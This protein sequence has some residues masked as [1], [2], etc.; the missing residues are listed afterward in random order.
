MAQAIV[1]EL[2]KVQQAIM[3]A[4]VRTA[5]HALDPSDIQDIVQDVNIRVLTGSFDP[6]KGSMAAW[7]ASMA[8][9]RAIDFIRR[10]NRRAVPAS[11]ALADEPEENDQVRI[12]DIDISD[13]HAEDVL[14]MIAADRQLGKAEQ[15]LA[16]LPPDDLHFLLI[17]MDEDFKYADYAKVLGMTEVALRVRKYR[18]TTKLRDALLAALS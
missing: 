1:E 7:A 14:H 4:A 16:S 3:D 2:L 6:A 12:E 10:K 9:N 11:D 15:V 8:H 5:G 17:S 13:P 18:I